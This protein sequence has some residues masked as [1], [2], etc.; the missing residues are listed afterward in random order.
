MNERICL[1]KGDYLDNLNQKYNII[2]DFYNAFNN[3]NLDLMSKVWSNTEKSFMANPIGGIRRGW[4]EISEGYKK[5][6]ASDLKVY[7]EFYDFDF[8]EVENM[9]IV[10]GK[11]RGTLTSED[12]IL[13]LSIR[14]SRTFYI[15]NNNWKHIVHH[16]SMDNPSL[17][18]EYQRIILGNK[19]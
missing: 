4:N 2:N 17:L 16:G 3:K 14:T 19:E 10:N 6:F 12:G 18:K 15:E 5:I 13:E 8:I 7:V 9:F 1:I 11:E